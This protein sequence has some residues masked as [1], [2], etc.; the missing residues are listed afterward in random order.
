MSV[1]EEL[2]GLVDQL[3]DG[4]AHVALVYLRDLLREDEAAAE[5]A[6]VQLERRMGP[7]AV[8]G[9]AFFAQQPADLP[10]LAARQGV[11]PVTS[12]E[13]LLGDFWPEDETAD[14]F[15]AAVR[16]WRHEGGDD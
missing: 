8:S 5:T 15:I 6:M 3:G 13:D 16:E 1:K 7:R 14:E 10:T 2:H 12:F 11:R 4:R 9:R